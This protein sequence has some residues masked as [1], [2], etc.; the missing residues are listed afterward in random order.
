[1]TLFFHKVISNK[2]Q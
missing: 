1:M 2:A